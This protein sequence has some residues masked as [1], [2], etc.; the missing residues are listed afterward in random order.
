MINTNTANPT[1]NPALNPTINQRNRFGATDSQ[2]SGNSGFGFSGQHSGSS[3]TF[4]NSS[5]LL[6]ILQ[7]IMR[8]LDQLQGNQNK[9]DEKPPEESV[10]N[11]PSQKPPEDPIQNPPG[12]NPS[13]DSG[14]TTKNLIRG[15]SGRDNLK[16]TRGDDRILGLAG[17]DRIRGRAGDDFLFG[18]QGK[19][20]IYGGKGNDTLS[21]GAGNDYLSGGQGSNRLFGG[22]G[23]D[24]LVSTGRGATTAAIK[25]T[26]RLD[27]GSGNDTARIR[28]RIDDY[29]IKVATI[30]PEG[31]NPGD[32]VVQGALA[33][34]GFILTDKTTGKTISVVNIENFRFNN[35][36]L[37]SDELKERLTNTDK[38]QTLDLTQEQQTEA[39]NLFGFIAS[40]NE[41]V[42]IQDQD[43]DG[44]ISVGDVAILNS[45]SSNPSEVVLTEANVRQITDRPTGDL[46]KL[47]DKQQQQ[48]LDLFNAPQERSRNHAITIYDSN[49]DGKVSK[50]DVAIHTVTP[51]IVPAVEG[52][53]SPVTEVEK[54][55]LTEA[56]AVQIN[57]ESDQGSIL[58]LSQEQHDAISLHFDDT[59][60]LALDG[61]ATK[62]TGTAVDKDGDGQLSVGDVV[63]LQRFGGLVN[64]NF[65]ED[66]VLTAKE[67]AAINN[68]ENS[69][70]LS[71][72]NEQSSAIS[73]R[74]NRTPPPNSADFITTRF[75]G[76][77]I[78]NNNDGKL[79]VGD[80]VKLRDTG[81][82]AGID[83][84]RDH[85]LTSEDIAAIN[86]DPD[87]DTDVVR[88][89]GVSVGGTLRD[90]ET[91]PNDR[92]VDINGESYTVGFLKQQVDDYADS[93]FVPKGAVDAGF[94]I[95]RWGTSS[96]FAAGTAFEKYIATTFP[97][98]E[99]GLADPEKLKLTQEQ[100]D[101][102]GAR[103][104]RKP[105]PNL[106]DAPTIQYTG[107]A[108][109]KDGDGQLGI[110]DV[111]KL[112]SLG[113]FTLPGNQ[114]I[115]RDHVLTAEDIAFI[116][117]DRSNPLLDISKGLSNEQRERLRGAINIDSPANSNVKYT[118]CV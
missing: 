95:H 85:V 98:G 89:G 5:S 114:D 90:G 33:D 52:Y 75:T 105:P 17:N 56:E 2:R 84:I 79:S 46:L 66:H 102:I 100:K 110:G 8:L 26:D 31:I 76:T 27:G 47:D 101:A 62:Y 30:F 28:G 55:A 3:S 91:I 23:N 94:G 25:T 77:A 42:S 38:P 36:R 106:F 113:G 20:R 48:A 41:Q 13:E 57:G 37:S 115:T 16:G 32:H 103:F 18:G 51:S 29:D 9:P 63:K 11:P 86:S 96:S 67:V 14:A 61:L 7:L 112:R 44:K 118:K 111:V 80:V 6:L 40:G 97:Q 117:S 43:G 65:V 39:L 104:N 50:G 68:S 73:N 54:K 88:G 69:Q 49:G 59:S 10:Q 92:V 4:N 71:L 45:S 1:L 35:S 93:S 82:I 81:G 19:D 58:N 60:A 15:T 74:F 108:I 34:N 53:H 70:K 116:E 24:T 64:T 72:T 22:A 21:G 78:D 87:T 99:S 109:D 107:T 83:Q 12:S